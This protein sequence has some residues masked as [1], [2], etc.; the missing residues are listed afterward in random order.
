MNGE[1]LLLS[2]VIFLH[3]NVLPLNG[4]QQRVVSSVFH[5]ATLHTSFDN[6]DDLITLCRL[7]LKEAADAGCMHL[8]D[9]CKL[10]L[11]S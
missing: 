2:F 10:N 3:K 6:Y 7:H 11:I 1:E 4:L 5:L 8:K 9:T